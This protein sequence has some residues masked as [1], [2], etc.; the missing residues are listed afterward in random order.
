MT[1][2]SGFIGSHIVDRLLLDGHKVRALVRENSD[3]SFLPIDRIEVFQGTLDKP[4]SALEGCDVVVHAAA[5]VS[6]W[7]AYD[8]FFNTNV[9]GTR[10]LLDAAKCCG[11]KHIIIISSNAVLGEE[12]CI[13]VKKEDAP[14]KPTMPYLLNRFGCSMNYYRETKAQQEQ[15]SIKFCQDNDINLTV[16]RPVWVYG[17]REFHAGPYE[18]CKTVL[19]GVPVLPM[20]T[21][22]RLHCVNVKDVARAVSLAIEKKQEGVQV[23][24]IGNEE[25]PNARDYF[26]LYCQY[27]GRT[28]PYYLSF[29]W[30]YPLGFLLEIMAKLMRS[31][32]PFLLTRARVKF[33][34]YNNIYDV[35]KAK[36]EL[37]FVPEISLEEG[38]KETVAWWME[39]GFLS[40]RTKQKNITGISRYML[41]AWL[42]LSIL[43]HYLKQL[44]TGKIRLA[45]YSQLIK[46]LFILAAFLKNYKTIKL[47][48]GY[49]IHLYLPAFGTK[50]IYTA[51]DKFVGGKTI[52]SHV[53]YSITKACPCNCAHCYQ[54]MD[55]NS[56]MPVELMIET[57]KKIQDDGVALFDIE[58]GESFARYK[59]LL[60]LVKALD[61]QRSELWVNTTG[62]LAGFD[63]LVELKKAGLYG[64]MVSIHHYNAKKHDGFLGREKSFLAAKRI[65]QI[66]HKV[67]LATVINCCPSEEMVKAGGLGKIMEMAKNLGCAYVQFIHEKPSGNLVKQG[68]RMMEP[69]F[70]QSQID[71]HIAYNKSPEYPPV[72]FQVYEASYLGCTAGGIERFYV[73][74]DG[75][76]QPCEFLNVSFGNVRDESYGVIYERM[77]EHFP[78]AT[79]NWL[80]NSENTLIQ[81]FIRMHGITR[82]P[83]KRDLT[84]EL[85]KQFEFGNRD[86]KFYEDLDLEK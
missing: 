7:G 63:Q 35:S 20:G 38:V 85:V 55:A 43:V 48:S 75:E 76:V 6:D 61:E 9:V 81:E 25:V 86:V 59:R 58:G 31:S 4:D 5:K 71:Q 56:S 34:Y 13:D 42:A 46:R 21:D 33:F 37:G 68:S 72:S 69:A 30:F 47:H 16:L 57:A 64:L 82:F 19:S 73:N 66:S 79:R 10:N 49:K 11:I 24:N 27:I 18:F 28:P 17:E 44:L 45:Q 51:L 80:C 26:N 65:I 23:Y 60:S 36:E 74:A 78:T 70:L 52:P 8:D 83:I 12:N 40:P 15:E 50:A 53:V 62:H 67:G 29:E 3:L 84:L 54:K 32:E 22:N 77:R 39:N 14:Y 41:N 2:A 1:G